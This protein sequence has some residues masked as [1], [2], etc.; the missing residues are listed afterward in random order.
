MS[1]R[2]QTAGETFSAPIWAQVVILGA[3]SIPALVLGIGIFFLLILHVQS[4]VVVGE[5]ILLFILAGAMALASAALFV[6]AID[7]ASQRISVTDSELLVDSLMSRK[8][9]PIANIVNPTCR[10]FGRGNTCLAFSF[11]D[12]PVIWH[13][14]VLS[15]AQ[16]KRIVHLLEAAQAKSPIVVATGT[17]VR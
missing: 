4:S 1:L 17:K 14:S 12:R 13:G 11:M 6:V 2:V 9:Y 7:I 5:A 16:I 3:I 8:A 15:T 10:E